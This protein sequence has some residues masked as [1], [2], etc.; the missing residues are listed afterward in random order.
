MRIGTGLKFS[1]LL[2][3]ILSSHPLARRIANPF[4]ST[5]LASKMLQKDHS[6]VLL[7]LQ[8]LH[9][10]LVKKQIPDE[11]RVKTTSSER[12]W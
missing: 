8:H 9:C 6:L 5:I 12:T 2:N 4:Y 11:P 7:Y 10:A 1:I 3:L